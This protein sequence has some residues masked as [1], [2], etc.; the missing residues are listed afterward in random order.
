MKKQAKKDLFNKIQRKEKYKRLDYSIKTM[1]EICSICSKMLEHWN[2]E[3]SE[4][5]SECSEKIM[6]FCD[7]NIDKNEALIRKL[8][9]SD[10]EKRLKFISSIDSVEKELLSEQW[11]IED[12]MNIE[13]LN[14]KINKIGQQMV[15]CPLSCEGIENK[16]KEGIIPRGLF[17]ETNGRTGDNIIVIVGMNPGR[18]QKDDKEYKDTLKDVKS[19]K[20]YA[21]SFENKVLYKHPYF[22]KTREVLGILNFNGPILWTEI[23]KCQSEENGKLPYSTIRKCVHT[24]LKEE[25]KLIDDSIIMAL[26]DKAYNTCLLIF[27]ER[28]IIGCPHPSGANSGFHKFLNDLKDKKQSI[29]KSIDKLKDTDTVHLKDII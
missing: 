21:K 14:I 2:D 17:L 29:V 16:K 4:I 10:F 3:G 5:C 18:M 6:E 25:V 9:K 28:K 7:N 24:F 8:M 13:E 11:V 27:P 26:G 20:N 15:N 23:V 12:K 1:A 19:Y 22:K